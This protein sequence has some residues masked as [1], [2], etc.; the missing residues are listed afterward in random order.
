MNYIGDSII[1][2]NCNFGAG[3]KIAN[4]PFDE[5]TVKVRIGDNKID[6]GLNK[7]GAIIGNNCRF[8]INTSI[9]PG[10]KIAPDSIIS[11]HT[12]ITRDVEVKNTGA[13]AK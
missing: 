6:T 1:G 13:V 9:M 10:V 2:D 7:F 8:G 5:G 3:T 11:P 4:Y 12:C